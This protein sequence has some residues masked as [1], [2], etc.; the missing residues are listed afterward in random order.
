MICIITYNKFTLIN[1]HIINF[2]NSTKNSA[3]NSVKYKAK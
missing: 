2:K 1:I 3:E